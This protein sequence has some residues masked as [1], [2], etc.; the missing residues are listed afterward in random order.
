MLRVTD[1]QLETLM[2]LRDVTIP[3]MREHPERV[4]FD[5]LNSPCG[6]HGCLLG[7]YAMQK[8]GKPAENVLDPYGS[9]PLNGDEFGIDDSDEWYKL[10]GATN[11]GTLDDRARY[12][13]EL[14]AQRLVALEAR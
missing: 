2:F 1:P 6:T 14:I 4:D 8:H 12:L 9:N 3:W 13:D 10:F 5:R 11:R 7:W